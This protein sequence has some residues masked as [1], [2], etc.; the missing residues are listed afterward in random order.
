[1]FDSSSAS[2]PSVTRVSRRIF[3]ATAA[4]ATAGVALLALG[5]HDSSALAVDNQTPDPGPPVTVVLFSPDGHRLQ[6]VTRSK[7][8]KSANE[9]KKQLSPGAYDITR[10]ADTELAYTGSL[11]NQHGT[12]IYR[13]ICCDSA[14]F[15][16]DTKF[17]SGTGWPS[18]WQPI[19]RENV[20]EQTDTSFGMERTAVA[21]RL[22][23]AH[24]GHVFND[25]PPPTGMRYCMNS[26]SLR[27]VAKQSA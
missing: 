20:A 26:A 4:T 22:C 14:L 25:G 11:W 6:A 8:V 5:R 12:G 27:F 2:D 24:L 3:L 19:A 16:S 10:L 17:E 13:C 15:S 23:D 21:C 1:M 9:W 18:F 7:V